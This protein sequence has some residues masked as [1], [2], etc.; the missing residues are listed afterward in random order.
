[1]LLSSVQFSHSFVS[2]SLQPYG[3]Q[4]TRLPCPSPTP[5]AYSNSCPL[6]QWCHW[7]ISSSVVPFSSCLQSFPASGSFPVSQF[8]AS[9]GQ[10]I[11]VSALTSVLPMNI[12]AWFP[13]GNCFDRLAIHSFSSIAS[14]SI[15]ITNKFTLISLFKADLWSNALFTEPGDLN[16]LPNYKPSLFLK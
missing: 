13:L 11:G 4:H 1:M 9:G 6:S 16:G 12:Q 10:S 3:L 15:E 8:F 2:N 7:T 14:L 5:G